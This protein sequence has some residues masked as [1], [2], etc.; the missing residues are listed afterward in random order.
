MSVLKEQILQSQ[1]LT[2]ILNLCDDYGGKE[3]WKGEGG[4]GLMYSIPKTEKSPITLMSLDNRQEVGYEPDGHVRNFFVKLVPLYD[5]ISEEDLK[6]I[7][8]KSAPIAYL[9]EEK[10]ES[11]ILTQNLDTAAIKHSD[12]LGYSWNFYTDW[13]EITASPVSFFKEE[14]R[15]QVELYKASNNN[16]D[17][18]IP[19]IYVSDIIDNEDKSVI[20]LLERKFDKGKIIFDMM[21][22]Y[23]KNKY[24]KFGIIVMPI[25]P[26]VTGENII[27]D[28]LYKREMGRVK[29][30]EDSYYYLKKYDDIGKKED[31]QCLYYIVQIVCCMIDLLNEGF[32]HGDL[33]LNNVLINPNQIA[34]TQCFESNGKPEDNSPFMGKV[35]II[36]FGTA[37]TVD[38]RDVPPIREVEGIEVFE[39]QIIT[40]LKTKGRHGFSTLDF[41]PYDWLPSLFLKRN[42]VSGKYLDDIIDKNLRVMY[43]LVNEFRRGRKEY[44]KLVIDEMTIKS[45]AFSQTLYKI[46]ET[47]A[48]GRTNSVLEEG[49]IIN[50]FF[51]LGGGDRK[52]ESLGKGKS[53]P[54]SKKKMKEALVKSI[55]AIKLSMIESIGNQM[56]ANLNQGAKSVENIGNY[57]ETVNTKRKKRRTRTRKKYKGKPPKRHNKSVSKS[58]PSRS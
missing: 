35:F 8:D 1:L 58:S 28:F 51:G 54:K 9:N 38:D 15:I 4:I 14:C 56:I 13:G 29:E 21:R 48:L 30:E 24:R 37:K 5:Q 23:L 18:F 52:F 11:Y 27:K 33:H 57:I 3:K 20:D 31:K 6:K 26:S 43:D 10:E 12:I 44:Q 7:D 32:I 50:N 45:D 39:K 17:S 2:K 55:F 49:S 34:S 19:P 40:I 42:S 41:P 16:L 46:R 53:S 22:G 47:N 25:M 36:D